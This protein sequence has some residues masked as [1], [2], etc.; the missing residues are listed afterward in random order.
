MLILKC[1]NVFIEIHM[2]FKLHII[3]RLKL[4]FLYSRIYLLEKIKEMNIKDL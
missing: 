2:K 3:I 4:I 1:S